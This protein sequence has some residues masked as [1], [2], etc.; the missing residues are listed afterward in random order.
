MIKHSPTSIDQSQFSP[1]LRE[2]LSSDWL[3][4]A[5]SEVVGSVMQQGMIFAFWSFNHDCDQSSGRF[6]LEYKDFRKEEEEEES[7]SS[8]Q[9]NKRT[10]DHC[11]SDWSP[12]IPFKCVNT[13]AE[14]M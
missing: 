5:V 11:C 9:N 6:L 1:V 7:S 10:G 4:P 13:Q 12:K 3:G 14:H 8:R 2:T